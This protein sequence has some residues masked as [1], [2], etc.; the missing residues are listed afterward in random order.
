MDDRNFTTKLTYI[1]AI[2]LQKNWIFSFE[3]NQKKK[4]NQEKYKYL[5]IEYYV[6]YKW[7]PVEAKPTAVFQISQLQI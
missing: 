3:S 5:P 6:S 4:K 7:K 2:C 1:A